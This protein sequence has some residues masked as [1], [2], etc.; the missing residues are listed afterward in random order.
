[1]T[2]KNYH[3]IRPL[4]DLGKEA[5]RKHRKKKQEGHDGPVVVHL[6]LPDCSSKIWPSDLV[7]Y[8]TWPIF[9]L[10]RDLT[11]TNIL[12]RFMII[13]QKMWPLECTQGFPRRCPSDLVFDWTWPI[14]KL[15]WDSIK[16]NI[17]IR[18]HDSQTENM[19]QFWT[20]SRLDQD[21]HSDQ[22][23]WLSNWKCGLWSVQKVFL[24]FDLVT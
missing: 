24:R 16:T 20:P 22:V 15:V 21:K 12:T 6:S 19:T 23:S 2:F 7:F 11:K 14:F 9:T 3:T 10:I 13:R 1:M 17:S 18:F 5:C 8:P 4:K